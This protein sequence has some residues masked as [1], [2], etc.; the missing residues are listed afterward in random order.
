MRCAFVLSIFLL[1]FVQS[2]S[3]NRF[4]KMIHNLKSA[5]DKAFH[6]ALLQQ[7]AN[8]RGN[9]SSLGNSSNAASTISHVDLGLED[10]V[11]ATTNGSSTFAD[12]ST[13]SFQIYTD[14]T[15]PTSPAPTKKCATA[16]TATVQCNSTVPLMRFVLFHARLRT[17]RSSSF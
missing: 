17:R 10:V 6:S 11:A 14:E 12:G 16:L 7:L 4:H 15:L 2:V 5:Q 1:V 8:S 9:D 13:S 3:P